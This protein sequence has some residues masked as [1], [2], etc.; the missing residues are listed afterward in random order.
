MAIKQSEVLLETE[1]VAT[2]LGTGVARILDVDEDTEACG[3]AHI[4]GALGINWRTD[5]QDPVRRDFIGPESFADLSRRRARPGRARG[6]S[7]C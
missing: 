7:R 4:P 6:R 5:L 1:Q 3:R 2:R